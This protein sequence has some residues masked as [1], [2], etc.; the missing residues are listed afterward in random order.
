[1]PDI[2]SPA[3]WNAALDGA[4][5]LLDGGVLRLLA[6]DGEVLAELRLRP[7]AFSPASG[8]ASL[9]APEPN[10]AVR[11]GTATRF[12]CLSIEGVLVLSG[13]CGS[14]APGE[15]PPDVDMLL[16]DAQLRAGGL[17]SLVSWVI[18]LP[19]IAT[20]ASGGMPAAPIQHALTVAD[21]KDI[22]AKELADHKTPAQA[23]QGT[24]TAVGPSSKRTT[25]SPCRSPPRRAS[26]TSR[27]SSSGTA[28]ACTR[29]SARREASRRARTLDVSARKAAL[30]APSAAADILESE[31]APSS[32]PGANHR[33]RAVHCVQKRHGLALWTEADRLVTEALGFSP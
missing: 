26:S 24:R 12:Q 13:A 23:Y 30:R 3:A 19:W 15:T 1:M 29:P 18:S 10:A 28:S 6:A 16:N 4:L 22:Y 8:Y 9:N 31:R 17:V 21:V 2:F 32:E 33:G 27:D 11:T 5:G 7:R 14:A 20:L 25:R